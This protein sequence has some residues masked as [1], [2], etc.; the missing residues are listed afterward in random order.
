[1]LLERPSTVKFYPIYVQNFTVRLGKTGI[2][3]SV[4]NLSLKHLQWLCKSC[5]IS[6]RLHMLGILFIIA[7]KFIL[8]F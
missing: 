2:I 6:G 7:L 1:M 3:S 5:Y 8:F 4:S